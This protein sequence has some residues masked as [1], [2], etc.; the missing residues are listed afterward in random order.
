MQQIYDNI[1]V[2]TV[3][4]KSLKK[5]PVRCPYYNVLYRQQKRSYLENLKDL[6]IHFKEKL[7]NLYFKKPQAFV[8]T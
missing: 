6:D 5:C 7:V 3:Y 2:Y 8:S 1:I 4:G